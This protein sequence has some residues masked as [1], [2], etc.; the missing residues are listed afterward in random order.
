MVVGRENCLEESSGQRLDIESEMNLAAGMVSYS[1]WGLPM[2]WALV[3][4]LVLDLEN[5]KAMSWEM[6]MAKNWEA[7]KEVAMVLLRAQMMALG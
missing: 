6:L 5:R 7:L 3:L 4:L 2:D 1:S